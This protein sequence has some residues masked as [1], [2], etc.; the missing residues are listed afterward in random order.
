MASSIAPTIAPDTVVS[1]EINPG[2]LHQYLETRPEGG[3]RLK[4]VQGS[5]TLVSPSKP[6]EDGGVSARQPRPGHL[7]GASGSA[8]GPEFDHLDLAIRGG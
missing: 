4:C 7:S 2:T 6:H 1:F 3:P 5:V 8:L